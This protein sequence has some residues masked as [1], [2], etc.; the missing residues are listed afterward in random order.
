MK[1]T[2]SNKLDTSIISQICLKE[3]SA[4]CFCLE[5]YLK[6][7]LAYMNFTAD[8]KYYNIFC[9]ICIERAKS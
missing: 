6:V 8:K 3:K 9:F 5:Y 7:R 4:V 1:M 2:M